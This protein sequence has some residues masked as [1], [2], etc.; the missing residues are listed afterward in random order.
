MRL[1]GRGSAKLKKVLSPLGLSASRSKQWSA[2]VEVRDQVFSSQDKT[3][4]PA[5]DLFRLPLVECASEAVGLGHEIKSKEVEG[6]H[7]PLPVDIPISDLC[8]IALNSSEVSAANW[9]LGRVGMSSMNT[10]MRKNGSRGSSIESAFQEEPET[11]QGEARLRDAIS[12]LKKGADDPEVARWLRRNRL[13]PLASLWMPDGIDVWHQ[14]GASPYSVFDVSI[15]GDR[16]RWVIGFICERPSDPEVAA[17]HIAH[18]GLRV[19]QALLESGLI[20]SGT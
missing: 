18:Q 6:L 19:R 11:P 1:P 15:V 12:F 2:W 16:P 3:K 14:S 17:M 5:G 13:N 4:R 20:R 9:L 7:Y 8:Q 10:F